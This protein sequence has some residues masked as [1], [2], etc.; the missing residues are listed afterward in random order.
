MTWGK[1][2]SGFILITLEPQKSDVLVVEGCPGADPPGKS[3]KKT[4]RRNC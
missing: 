3:L 2:C 1:V 4:K